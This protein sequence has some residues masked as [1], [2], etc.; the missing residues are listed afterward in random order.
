[1][2]Y[3]QS[4]LYI[5]LKDPT[6]LGPSLSEKEEL[7]RA[8][9]SLIATFPLA[10]RDSFKV[11]EGAIYPLLSMTTDG[12]NESLASIKATASLR[13]KY[14]LLMVRTYNKAGNVKIIWH[15]VLP[16]G[17][18]YDCIDE[19]KK[20]LFFGEMTGIVNKSAFDYGN[21]VLAIKSLRDKFDIFLYDGFRGGGCAYCP[22]SALAIENVLTEQGYVGRKITSVTVNSND[23]LSG[24]F[25]YNKKVS[26]LLPDGESINVFDDMNSYYSDLATVMDDIYF[27]FTYYNT[28]QPS[29]DCIAMNDQIEDGL[30]I[31]SND[32]IKVRNSETQYIYKCDVV[33]I[34]GTD[35]N[36]W[37]F[38]KESSNLENLPE[39]PKGRIQ[40]V[41][42]PGTGLNMNQLLTKIRYFYS[43][44]GI[45][46]V[47]KE[48]SEVYTPL[49][50]L[51]MA[52][53]KDKD[54][55]SI[56]GKT[57][58]K[59]AEFVKKTY[60]SILSINFFDEDFRH[61]SFVTN[62]NNLERGDSWGK[63]QIS[64]VKT[65]T[66]NSSTLS[67]MKC[68]NDKLKLTA[69][70]ILHATGHNANIVHGTC[71]EL[72]AINNE[73][74]G[75]GYMRSGNVILWN[76]GNNSLCSN[77]GYAPFV[78]ANSLEE[79][80]IK[81]PIKIIERVKERYE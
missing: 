58:L 47:V 25:R 12:L 78:V 50:R 41:L 39:F 76:L 63:Q 29:N 37:V 7:E 59:V 79:F 3:A 17:Q 22:S 8:A 69:F 13:S 2:G 20:Q 67:A 75:L 66:M 62:P 64:V 33:V 52:N 36:R 30:A 48:Y 55:I 56:V 19:V 42:L 38:V 35:G 11:I 18:P 51:G 28:S 43:L 77:L 21:I 65:G 60:N 23:S 34:D 32:E 57:G 5:L 14:H 15:L 71:E 68:P 26:I 16:K 46:P 9:D 27:T 44:I 80:I 4:D 54:A 1:M 31:K 49:T 72:V 6:G 70:M 74:D 10:Y 24:N 73:I 45:S 81:T 53:I 40:I 61:D